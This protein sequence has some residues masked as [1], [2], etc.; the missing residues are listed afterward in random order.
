MDLSILKR[1]GWH[2][3]RYQLGGCLLFAALLPYVIRI[4][5][6]P[7][8]LTQPVDQALFGSIAAIVLGTWLLRNVTTYPGVEKTTYVLPAFTLSYAALLVVLIVTRLEYNRT[9]L[10]ASFAISIAWYLTLLSQLQRR[11]MLR[12][13]LLPFG[14]HSR[15]RAIEGITWVELRSADAPAEGLDAVST[16]LRADVPNEWDRRLADFALSGVPVYH[17]KHLLESLTGRVELEHLSENSFGSLTPV[18]AFMSFKAIVDWVVALLAGLVLW[19]FLIGIGVAIRLTSP[20]PA[21]FRQRRI[22][23][24]GQP[25]TVYKFRTMT[26]LTDTGGDA[27]D[28]AMTQQ[29]DNRITPIGRFLRFTR[30]DE[31]PQILNI[32]LGEMSWIG[33]RPEAE[34]LSRWYEAELPFYRYR[35][36]VRP[37]ITGWA[38]V[39]QGH[40]VDI[41]EVQSKLHYDFYYIKHYSA[42]IDLL[43]IVRTVRTVLTGFGSR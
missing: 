27:R 4:L 37:G 20:G 7:D 32:L 6:L 42:W 41:G 11:I 35:H 2:R 15:L 40:V 36:I 5:T 1:P 29:G 28:A 33:P 26:V 3:L 17:S 12:I 39:C 43:I 23:H 14:D 21:L 10:L 30:I 34:V 9:V 19:P 24:K 25:F 8:N 31:L 16:D 18:S 22:G 13:G 38:Q